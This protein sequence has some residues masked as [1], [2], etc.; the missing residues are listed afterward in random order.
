MNLAI[1]QLAHSPYCIPITRALEA[2]GVPFEA[3]EVSNADRR[4][5]IEA[6]GGAYYQVPVLIHDGNAVHESSGGSTDIAHYVDRVFA[7]GRL[8]PAHLEGLQRIL[9]PHIEDNVES[10]TF[11]LVDPSYL[12][13]IAD[14]VERAMIVR[15][16][17]RK[18]GPGCIGRWEGEREALL[19]RA[20]ELL[21]P[22]DLMLDGRP[23]LL[24]DAPVFTDFAL[25]GILGNFTYRG[26]NAIPGKLTRLAGWFDRLRT[27]RFG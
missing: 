25:C 14:P 17:E 18:F 6:T 2:L 21:E 27:F 3:R 24:G 8:F 12:R 4:T 11:R 5:V 10:V 7:G 20:G 26:Y 19:A 16:K 15:H 23:F 22:F 9:V 13:D 1:L